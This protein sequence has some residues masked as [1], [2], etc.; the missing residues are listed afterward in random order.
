MKRP[1]EPASMPPE[2]VKP[3]GKPGKLN[4]HWRKSFPDDEEEGSDRGKVAQV[5]DALRLYGVWRRVPGFWKILASDEGFIATEGESVA[6]TP[7]VGYNHYL[8]VGCNGSHEHVHNLVCRAFKGRPTSEQT[9]ADHIGGRELPRAERRRDN[10][11]VNLDWATAAEQARNRRKAKAKSNGEPCLVWEVKGGKLKNKPNAYDATP[12]ENTEQRFASVLAAAKALGLDQGNLSK[13]FNG[14]VRTLTGTDGTRYAGKWDP[15]LADLEGEAWKEVAISSK[16]RLFVSS[17]GR[18]QFIYPGHKGTKHYP[19]SCD[20]ENDYHMVRI[21]KQSKSV[22]ILVGELFFIGPKPR[23][24]ACW[25][26]KDRDRQNNHIGNLRP[27]TVEENGVNTAR[28]RDFYLWPKNN[29]DDWVRCVSQTGTARAYGFSSSNIGDVL[30]KRPN[31][32][33]SVQ[34]TVGGYCAAFCDEVY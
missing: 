31:K 22:H 12:V 29:P 13:I 2:Y 3:K 6:R 15:D 8:R 20:D 16:N 30:H 18:L 7:T 23:N 5:P 25:D 19:E 11:A 21:G 33:G 14:T 4:P 26:H 24:W 17:W 27:V 10:R 9:S 28:Q 32:H 1:R 34:K